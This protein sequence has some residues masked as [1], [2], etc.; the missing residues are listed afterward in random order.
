MEQKKLEK[1]KCID[2]KTLEIIVTDSK[3]LDIDTK[4]KITPFETNGKRHNMDDSFAFGIGTDEN[5]YNFPFEEK[6]G[7]KQFF[8]KYLDRNSLI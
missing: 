7:S 4:I 2:F 5:D 1:N 8:I 6:M 3:V